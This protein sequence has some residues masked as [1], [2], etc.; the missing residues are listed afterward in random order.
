MNRWLATPA[1]KSAIFFTAASTA[2]SRRERLLVVRPASKLGGSITSSMTRLMAA[3][4]GSLPLI[5]R[6]IIHPVMIR[7]LI[8]FVPSK[9]RL[10][11]ASR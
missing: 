6:F 9:M 3:I 7:R 8:S 5:A 11:R 4:S 10:M 2:V 1:A